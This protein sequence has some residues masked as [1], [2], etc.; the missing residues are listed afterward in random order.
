MSGRVFCG[1]VPRLVL[2][3]EVP[4]VLRVGPNRVFQFQW[5]ALELAG[6]WQLVVQIEAIETDGLILL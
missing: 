2:E 6:I 5:F 4:P 1:A 3:S